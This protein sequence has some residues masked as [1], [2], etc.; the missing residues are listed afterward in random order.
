MGLVFAGDVH[1]SRCIYASHPSMVGD[2]EFA[3][4]Q[5]TDFCKKGNHDL[6]L[7][8]DNFDK[9]FP[10]PD[11]VASFLRAIDGLNVAYIVGQ[12][13][14]HSEVQWPGVSALASGQRINLHSKKAEL[15]GIK[16]Y[17]LNYQPRNELL[18]ALNKIPEDTDVLCLHQMLRQVTGLDIWQLSMEEVPEFVDYTMLGDWH[19]S[20][21]TGQHEGRKWCYT[22]SSTMRSIDEPTDKTFLLMQRKD[23]GLLHVERQPLKT[24]P[25]FYN[26]VR[27]DDELTKYLESIVPAVEK[28]HAEANVPDVIK[29]PFVCLRYDTGIDDA[30][31]RIEKV[32][33][34]LISKGLVHL[35][36][37]T[38]NN[39]NNTSPD[40][41]AEAAGSVTI[42]DAIDEAVD[43]ELTPD[44]HELAS[45]LADSSSPK[46]V[47]Q[48]Y[49]MRNQV[50]NTPSA[51]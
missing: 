34:P 39:F 35:H 47:I 18:K 22:G 3:L 4:T 24:R 19:G 43:K 6:I 12:H 49:K 15:Q 5:I 41:A 37:L 30:F 42:Q 40:Y 44:L 33:A 46:E 32:L 20:S 50:L 51:V 21:Q 8:G 1:L 16:L 10:E 17:G 45:Q 14:I 7:L 2:S 29:A 11:V 31:V 38:T 27:W 13:D 48:A 9:R 26:Q 28:A 25:F 23:D 36:L